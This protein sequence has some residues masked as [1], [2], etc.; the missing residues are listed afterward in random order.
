MKIVSLKHMFALCRCS[1]KLGGQM[2]SI[3]THVF[4][5]PHG[6]RYI[7]SSYMDFAS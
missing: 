4:T 5:R 1:L 2:F 3:T 7:A 6:V